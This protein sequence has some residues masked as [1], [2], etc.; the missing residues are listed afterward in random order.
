MLCLNCTQFRKLVQ[1]PVMDLHAQHEK[2]HTPGHHE[3]LRCG[4]LGTMKTLDCGLPFSLASEI[5]L[6]NHQTYIRPSTLRVYKQY[7]QSLATFY[8]DLTL[9][10]FHIGHVRA[11]QQERKA[12]P[13]R[14]NAEVSSVLI[15]VLR[16]VN[17]WHTMKDVYRPL[18]VPKKRVRKT[19]G[20]D[21]Q[22]RLLAVALDSSKPRRL[23]AGHCLIV[24]VNTGMG[25]GELRHLRRE[26]VVLDDQIPY[27]AVNEGTKNEFRVRTVPLNWIA[28]RSMRW[29]VHR[30]ES[31]GGT[32]PNQYILPHAATR[33]DEERQSRG[34]KRKS[35]PDF[36]TPMNHIYRGARAI[37][38]EAGLGDM[39]P[40]DMRSSA[41][42]KLMGDPDLSEQGFQEI[43]GHSDTATRKRYLLSKLQKKAVAMERIAVDPAPSHKLL[44]F[45][46]GKR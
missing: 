45:T 15:P 31:L 22:R 40:Y 7:R 18:P 38:K 36:Y 21:E 16:E 42:T 20:D 30:W 19:M 28:L 2:R 34:H 32:E 26:D 23:L 24:M 29:I 8:G 17:Q 37:L 6:N 41:G 14:V 46:G 33:S 11:Y 44:V 39:V 5:W 13:T 35:P 1:N 4:Y 12:C 10:R 3:C 9:G 25:F 27:A 43:F